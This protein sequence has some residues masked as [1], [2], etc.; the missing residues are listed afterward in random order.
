MRRHDG[1]RPRANS[2]SN[3]GGKCCV[4]QLVMAPF[5]LSW[6]YGK[7]WPNVFE[8]AGRGAWMPA[9]SSRRRNIQQSPLLAQTNR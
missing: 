1:R 2:A 9:N 3:P 8:S 5:D 4:G 6:R 7:S